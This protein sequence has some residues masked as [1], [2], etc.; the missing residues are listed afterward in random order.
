MDPAVIQ[1]VLEGF[2]GDVEAD[3]QVEL[4]QAVQL[5]RLGQR[6]GETWPMQREWIQ[7]CVALLLKSQ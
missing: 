1:S 5:L 2:I 7:D 6:A 4:K 3:D